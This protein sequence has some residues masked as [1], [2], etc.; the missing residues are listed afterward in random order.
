[1]INSVCENV[2][3]TNNG[4]P[5]RQVFNFC[6]FHFSKFQ[7]TIAKNYMEKPS[8]F[9]IDFEGSNEVLL[10]H[11]YFWS[12]YFWQWNDSFFKNVWNFQVNVFCFSYFFYFLRKITTS[13][14]IIHLKCAVVHYANL[15]SSSIE[16]VLF[17]PNSYL[18]LF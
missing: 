13:L 2:W 1:M 11:K 3:F 4:L 17:F 10:C 8:F 18:R 6:L 7:T 14:F 5:K 9:I 15:N 12:T 16:Y